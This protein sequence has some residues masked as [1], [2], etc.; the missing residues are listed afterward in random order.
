MDY[1]KET[2]E[3]LKRRFGFPLYVFD[4][5]GFADN[6][7]ALER[8]MK[9]RCDRYQIAYSFKTNY[10]PYICSVVKRLGGNAE[11]VSGMEYAIAKRVG[12]N[13]RQ[14]LFNGPASS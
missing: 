2:V 14:I 11:V 3:S 7:R 13:D 4:E 1:T 9:A 5:R 6:Y 8:A 12:F 10:T